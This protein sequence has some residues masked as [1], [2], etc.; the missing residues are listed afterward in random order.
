MSITATGAADAVAQPGRGGGRVVEVARAAEAVAG[1]VVAGRPAERV[2]GAA[3]R[4]ATRSAAVSAASTAAR[5][6]SQV[7]GP[8]QRHRVVGEAPGPGGDRRRGSPARSRRAGPGWGRGRGRRGPGRGRPSGRPRCQSLPGAARG[9]RA[10]RGS[11]TA[12]TRRVGVGARRRPG[13]RRPASSAAADAL[14][15]LGQLGARR[16]HADPDLAA[17]LVQPVAVAPDDGHRETHGG[18][19]NRTAA[20]AGR[21]FGSY[22]WR[23]GELVRALDH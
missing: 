17:R 23:T 7:P 3:R 22:E 15:A 12:S 16:A 20:R 5:A 1:G 21:T 2:G 18:E 19:P 14:R 13:G 6:A 11:W 9:S 8:D 10:A 4:R